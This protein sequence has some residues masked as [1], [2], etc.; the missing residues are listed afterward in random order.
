MPYTLGCDGD[1]T[2]AIYLLLRE[3]FRPNQK[4]MSLILFRWVSH[5]DLSI[6]EYR[7]KPFGMTRYF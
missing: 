7:A 6:C 1:Y 5:N 4:N 3:G 2:S